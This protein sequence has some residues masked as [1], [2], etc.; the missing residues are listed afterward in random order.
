MDLV[1]VGGP[2]LPPLGTPSPSAWGPTLVASGCYQAVANGADYT[3][4]LGD[5]AITVGTG[6]SHVSIYDGSGWDADMTTPSAA[7][8]KSGAYAGAVVTYYQYV[9]NH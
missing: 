7:P 6:T 2:M 8:G 1:N 9:G 3:P 4:Q 5:I